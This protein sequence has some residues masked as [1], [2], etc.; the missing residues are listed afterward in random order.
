VIVAVGHCNFDAERT[1]RAEN[2]GASRAI[3]A[4]ANGRV[5]IIIIII[6]MIITMTTTTTIFIITSWMQEHH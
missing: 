2:A 1:R 3:E 6:V 4:A 5:K